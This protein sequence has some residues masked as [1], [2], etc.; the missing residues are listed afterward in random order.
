VPALWDPLSNPQSSGDFQEPH[1]CQ[2]CERQGPF[3]VN[4]DQSEFIDS[5]KLRVQE[6]PEGLR[7]G[8]TPQALDINI[9]DDI[10]GEVTPG[11]H[12]SAIG[13]LRLEQQGDQQ[14]KSPVFDFYME[15]SP[16]R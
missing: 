11:D 3:R 5:Q 16:S 12:V 4:F 13:V 7:G 2:G 1:E 8:E 9:E 10:T 6:S 15:G 14:D